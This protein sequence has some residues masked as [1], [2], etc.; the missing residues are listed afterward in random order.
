MRNISSAE[1]KYTSPNRLM[2]ILFFLAAVVIFLGK[3]KWDWNIPYL[4]W[5]GVGCITLSILLFIWNKT[6]YSLVISTSSG[7]VQALQSTKKYYITNVLDKL[8]E[9][10]IN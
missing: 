3:F 4:F 8:N 10:I 2:E 9:A 1:I 7:E 6:T 5:G